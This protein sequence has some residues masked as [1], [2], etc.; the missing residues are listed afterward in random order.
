M[1]REIPD[2]KSF[3]VKT[4]PGLRDLTQSFI[5]SSCM[6]FRSIVVISKQ[7]VFYHTSVLVV[8]RVKN[9]QFAIDQRSNTKG[10]KRTS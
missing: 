3:I 6:P 2:G 9:V 1:P 7:V 10:S 8:N 5:N 4:S